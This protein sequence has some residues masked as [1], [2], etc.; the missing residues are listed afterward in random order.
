VIGGADDDPLIAGSGRSLLIGVQG[1]DVLLPW[2]APA[3]GRASD[4][5]GE[6]GLMPSARPSALLQ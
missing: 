4:S 5:Q 1:G 6:Q 2:T 3:V